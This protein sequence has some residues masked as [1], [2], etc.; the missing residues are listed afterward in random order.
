MTTTLVSDT[1]S[2]TLFHRSFPERV[3][4][5]SDH[6][7]QYCSKGYREL[8]STYNLKQSMDR[9]GNCWDNVYIES[10]FHA[11]KVEAVLYELIMSRE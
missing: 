2:I 7:S 1:L 4:V 5:H 10:F 9:K 8:I 6:G 3:I 11:M